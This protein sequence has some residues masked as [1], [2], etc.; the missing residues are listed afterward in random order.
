MRHVGKP[1][2]NQMSTLADAAIDEAQWQAEV[3]DC[4]AEFKKLY[5][6]RPAAF[7][8]VMRKHEAWLQSN[9]FSN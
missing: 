5:A 9:G 3:S 6:A 2:C 7:A 4:F 1:L 8:S